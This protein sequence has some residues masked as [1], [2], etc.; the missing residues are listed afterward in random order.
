[1]IHQYNTGNQVGKRKG[2][3]EYPAERKEQRSLRP[4]SL[5]EV[6]KSGGDKMNEIVQRFRV[7]RS[8][9]RTKKALK[10]QS[11]R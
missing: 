10:T 8:G 11:A 7:Q 4:F 9:L 3:F 5:W 1:M 2:F 6:F